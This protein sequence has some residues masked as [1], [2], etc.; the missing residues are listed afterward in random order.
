MEEFPDVRISRCKINQVRLH[1]HFHFSWTS[2]DHNK[3][4]EHT[5]IVEMHESDFCSASL[6]V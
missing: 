1:I 6:T 5:L 4:V 3:S 2:T